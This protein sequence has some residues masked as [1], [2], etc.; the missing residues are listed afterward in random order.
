MF[1]QNIDNCLKPFTGKTSTRYRKFRGYFFSTILNRP[2]TS[3][4]A[5]RR[6]PRSGYSIVIKW[7][8]GLYF[9]A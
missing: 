8:K 3:G 9:S 2:D 5:L 7:Q 6:I 4:Q 1:E